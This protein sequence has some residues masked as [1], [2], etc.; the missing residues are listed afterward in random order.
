MTLFP[1]LPH[2][3]LTSSAFYG[4]LIHLLS[5]KKKPEGFR[6]DSDLGPL[7]ASE[8]S[9]LLHLSLSDIPHLDIRFP[10][11]RITRAPLPLPGFPSWILPCKFPFFAFHSHRELASPGCYLRKINELIYAQ[12]LTMTENQLARVLIILIYLHFVTF[13][14]LTQ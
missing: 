3:L 14:A 10:F 12:V 7:L 9:A 8:I 2:H 1:R 6:S 4:S 13:R 5:S 11:L